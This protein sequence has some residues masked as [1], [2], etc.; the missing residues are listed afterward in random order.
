MTKR[1]SPLQRSKEFFNHLN[2]ETMDLVDDF[3]DQDVVFKDPLVLFSNR[4]PLKEYYR[5]LYQNVSLIRF[6][7]E[8]EVLSG[9]Q[10]TFSW[11]MEMTCGLNNGEPMSVNGISTIRFGGKEGKAVYHRDYY[12]MGEFVYERIPIVK[13]VIKLIKKKMLAH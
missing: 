9:P 1:N 2:K 8:N 4:Q 6:T 7:F 13:S 12:D 3:Y 5:G 11:T 10:C